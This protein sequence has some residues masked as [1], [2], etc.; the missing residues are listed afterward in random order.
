MRF[1]TG[2]TVDLWVGP[3]NARR[4]AGEND[5]RIMFAPEGKG[6]GVVAVVFH[7]KAT[8]NHKRV[9]FRSPSGE[10]VMDRVEP[11]TNVAACVRVRRDGYSLE[12]AVPWTDLGVGPESRRIGLDFSIN[13]S[14][15]AG[16]RNVARIHWG[17][18]GAAI[19]YDVPSEARLEPETWGVG[20]MASPHGRS[21]GRKPE[22]N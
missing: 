9:S 15:P 8:T 7:P 11:A 17:R 4:M 10:V 12:A 22:S 2:D 19:V 20:I 13:F 5:R 6:T 16:E 1:K 3:D 21:Q 14:N 18:N